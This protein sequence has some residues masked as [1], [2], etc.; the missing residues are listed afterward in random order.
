MMAESSSASAQHMSAPIDIPAAGNR[1]RVLIC[2]MQGTAAVTVLVL[3]RAGSRNET[4]TEHGIAHF[5]EHLFFKGGKRYQ[6]PLA[7]SAAVD[8][9][10]GSFNA[11]TGKEYVGYYVKC[12]SADAERAFDVLGDMLLH[13]KIAPEDIERERGVILE[14]LRMYQ[15]MP[16]Y[17]VGWEAEKLFFGE[18]SPMGRDQI[19][20]PATLAAFTQEDFQ[21]Y[22]QQLYTADNSVVVVAGDV[23]PERAEELANRYF[24][25]MP[26]SRERAPHGP[27]S[28]E[29]GGQALRVVNK[30]TEQAHLVLG[31]PGVA[32][33]SGNEA[34]MRVLCAALGGGMSSRL[35]LKIREEMG[36]CYAIS[37]AADM[38]SDVGVL[39]VSAGVDLRRTTAA[40]GATAALLRQLAKDGFSAEEVQRAKGYLRGHITLQ[41]E[42][43]ENAANF[44]GTSAVL[45]K[46][47]RTPAT[48]LADI[49]AV[50]QAQVNELAAKALAQSA[51]LA[52]IG[53]FDG[54]Q[55]QLEEALQG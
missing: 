44:F 50:G 12:A 39:A 53:P 23:Q 49:A 10:G 3:A 37:S 5:L 35:F 29:Q 19:G 1:P 47:L 45:G 27:A 28:F 41:M 30:K 26:P 33:G 6:N 22:R 48:F 18:D 13:A 54:Q 21:H 52:M 7:V 40:L 20:T 55:K 14:E 9:I 32:R 34:T 2:P 25:G 31:L 42:D 16:T 51:K 43:C 8:E 46:S 4:A 15:D 38:Y 24:A 36:L 11:F 17:Q